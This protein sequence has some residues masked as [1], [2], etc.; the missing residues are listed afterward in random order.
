MEWVMRK[1]GICWID[2]V[3]LCVRSNL[4]SSCATSQNHPTSHD[5]ALSTICSKVTPVFIFEQIFRDCHKDRHRP[6]LF[7][8]QPGCRKLWNFQWVQNA[9]K[10]L[11]KHV[12]ANSRQMHQFCTYM[13]NCYK[14]EELLP[15]KQKKIQKIYICTLIP[16]KK[17]DNKK[18]KKMS[19]KRVNCNKSWIHDIIA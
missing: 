13:Q 14:K 9:L 2:I 7:H 3:L 16:G 15:T 8:I 17:I 12:F 10:I 6:G 11:V 4:F 19:K 18:M 5:V 1:I